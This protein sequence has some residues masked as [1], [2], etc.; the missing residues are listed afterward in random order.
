MAVFGPEVVTIVATDLTASFVLPLSDSSAQNEIGCL[1]LA[2]GTILSTS[3]VA[4]AAA[5]QIVFNDVSGSVLGKATLADAVAIGQ[6]NLTARLTANVTNATATMANLTGLSM[7]LAAGQKYVGTL[8]LF[9]SNSTAADGVKLDFDGGAATMTSFAA[10]AIITDSTALVS[11]QRTTALATD[12]T[13]ATI[14]GNSLVQIS[15]GMVVNAGG[16]FIPRVA[17]NSVSTGILTASLNSQ[18]VLQIS[19]A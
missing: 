9:V 4:P 15:F 2:R 5:D 10:H 7:T 12:I 19:S 13:A 16:T 17:M 11:S 18:M 3:L 1:D 8:S 6:S 14:T